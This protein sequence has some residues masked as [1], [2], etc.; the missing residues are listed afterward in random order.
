M[1]NCKKII[2]FKILKK[3]IDNYPV[4][5]EKI[6]VTDDFV[7]KNV[8]YIFES[9]EKEKVLCVGQVQSGKTANII[10]C[11]EHALNINYKIII[12]IGG[13]TNLLLNQTKTRIENSLCLTNDIKIL[14]S[15]KDIEEKMSFSTNNKLIIVC[16]KNHDVLNSIFQTLDFM[17]LSGEDKK[18][19]FIDDE[20]DYGSINT[21]ENS[22]IH[23]LISN[24][25]DRFHHGK[26]LTFT[27]TPFANILSENSSQIK[28]DRIVTLNNY[29]DYCGLKEFNQ[30][31]CYL[32]KNYEK[33]DI[34]TLYIRESLVYWLVISSILM[35]DFPKKKSQFLINVEHINQNQE[36]LKR[37]V[38]N[39]LN[40]FVNVDLFIIRDKIQKLLDELYLS[41]Y[42]DQ[43][44]QIIFNIKEISIFLIKNTDDCVLILNSKSNSLNQNRNNNFEIIIS[45]Y[46]ASRGFTFD[47][48]I[49]ELFLN[50]PENET[51]IDTLLQKC[52]WFGN[53]KKYLKYIKI[54]T[55][56]KIKEA[57]NEA[58]NY[59]NIFEPGQSIKENEIKF[60][61]NNLLLLDERNKKEY[62][63]VVSTDVSK[64]V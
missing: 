59:I 53:R 6:K 40:E 50:N 20:C 54:I 45:G 8:S 34:D 60:L 55:N 16:L 1:S 27:G 62:K 39:S 18:I 31:N 23:S 51:K 41:E 47:D 15:K 10:K 7:E 25:Y 57:L 35:I 26:M 37:I 4:D 61:K 36:N 17:N 63:G 58:I 13:I 64:R 11:I 43:V 33:G 14:S 48:L 44:E 5:S 46:M 32:I 2:G 12:V 28:P 30:T 29:P 56:E 19:L 38:L 21:S 22:K 49:C 24:I 52:R 3:C 42:I 9:E